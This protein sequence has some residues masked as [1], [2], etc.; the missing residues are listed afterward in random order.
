MHVK[1][2]VPERAALTG[3]SLVPQKH[4]SGVGVADSSLVPLEVLAD[5]IGHDLPI[6]NRS[7]GIVL[8]F[9]CQVTTAVPTPVVA[10]RIHAVKL[11]ATIGP[12]HELQCTVC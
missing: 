1:G 12:I 10:D 7:H 4:E 6:G 9:G 8:V 5:A 11:F 2:V 3:V